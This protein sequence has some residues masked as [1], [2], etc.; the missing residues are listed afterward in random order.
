[1]QAVS[2]RE[3]LAAAPGIKPGPFDT[4]TWREDY[5]DTGDLVF[6]TNFLHI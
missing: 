2:V 3:N 4:L 6:S 1:M 5:L